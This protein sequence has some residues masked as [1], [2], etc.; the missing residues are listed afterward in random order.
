MPIGQCLAIGRVV[1]RL[2]LDRQTDDA[3]RAFERRDEKIERCSGHRHPPCGPIAGRRSV[4]RSHCQGWHIAV[5][6]QIGQDVGSG[7]GDR[8]FFV[9]P[10]AQLRDHLTKRRRELAEPAGGGGQRPSR[11][12]DLERAPPRLANAA[13]GG[14]VPGRMGRNGAR[15]QIRDRRQETFALP[16]LMA[17]L[18]IAH[19]HEDEN[20]TTQGDEGGDRSDDGDPG[21]RRRNVPGSPPAR[22][23]ETAPGTGARL[24]CR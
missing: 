5:G 9:V 18:G 19:A 7:V 20:G 1:G 23:P 6:N 17:E 4:E 24:S 22:V 13:G 21:R 15:T 16:C 10:P 11:R 3:G 8:G 2:R 14:G 12:I